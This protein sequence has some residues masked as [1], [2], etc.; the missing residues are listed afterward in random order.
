MVC[1]TT[2]LYKIMCLG[3][4][5]YNHFAPS[6]H[7]SKQHEDIPIVKFCRVLEVMSTY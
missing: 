6:M 1:I 5:A 3:I 4:Y 2:I 7:A